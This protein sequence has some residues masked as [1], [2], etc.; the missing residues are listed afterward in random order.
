MILVAFACFLV[1]LVAWLLASN[2]EG[3]PEAVIEPTPRLVEA[4][5]SVEMA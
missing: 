3:T 5:A 1:L 4:K 2:I